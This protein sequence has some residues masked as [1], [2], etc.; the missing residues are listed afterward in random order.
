MSRQ[1]QAAAA[2]ESLPQDA[3]RSRA[4]AGEAGPAG[5][6]APGLGGEEQ[7]APRA[8]PGLQEAN[9]YRSLGAPCDNLA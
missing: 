4:G 6:A 5:A 8:P 7:Q 2:G 3:P 1:E 9:P